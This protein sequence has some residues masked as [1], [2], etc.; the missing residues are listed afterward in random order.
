M[1]KIKIYVVGGDINYANWIAN[2]ELVD[3]PEDAKIVMFTGGEDVD[4]SLYGKEK[5]ETTHSNIKRDLAE[6][7]IFDSLNENQCVI[8][9]CR[10]SQ[11]CC[12][13]NGGL[14]VQNCSGHA[15][16]ETHEISDGDKTTSITS[17][18]HQMQ[19]PWTIPTEEYDVIFW[20]Q[21]SLSSYYTGDGIRT[22]NYEPEIVLYHRENKPKCLA[23]QGH[24]EIMRKDAPVINILNELIQ[25]CLIEDL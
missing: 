11:L 15:L 21:P 2:A 6:K 8:G 1:E 9:I 5:H 25:K 23:I 13:L 3:K 17:T 14:L 24:P 12:V 19:Y 16:W 4:P 22:V 10:G 7:E 20:A 18:H